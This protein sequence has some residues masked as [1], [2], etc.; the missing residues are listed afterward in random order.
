VEG[1]ELEKEI[2][3]IAPET[4]PPTAPAMAMFE[5]SRSWERS[6][7]VSPAAEAR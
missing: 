6:F 1:V 7:P 5:A 2:K 4:L 3:L